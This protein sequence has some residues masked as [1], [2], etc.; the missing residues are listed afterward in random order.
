MP[1]TSNGERPVIIGS[2]WS[3][4]VWTRLQSNSALPCRRHAWVSPILTIPSSVC[5]RTMSVSIAS[6]SP[7][8]EILN[9]C[10]KGRRS[11]MVSSSVI[12]KRLVPQALDADGADLVFGDLRHGVAGGVGQ[13]V[14]R[15]FFELHERYEHGA[16]AHRLR[17]ARVAVE[18]AA[19]R[20]QTDARARVHAEPPRIARMDR[21][22]QARRAPGERPAVPVVEQ[23]ARV[24]DERE[25]AVGKLRGLDRLPRGDEARP[26]ER[27]G[28]RVEI[29]RARVLRGRAWPLQTAL[30]IEPRV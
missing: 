7:P 4:T 8:C 6:R 12:F 16:R 5:T 17:D 18:L 19:A 1:A 27:E 26:A 20:G 2:K 23:A 3:L 10:A 24:E 13:E 11:G 15:R 30:A 29:T 25:V 14:R 28:L 9:G 22:L 21:H